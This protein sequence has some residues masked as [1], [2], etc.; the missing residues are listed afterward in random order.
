MLR[1]S[2]VP[3]RRGLQCIPRADSAA[4]PPKACV[5]R[6]S[7]TLR[8]LGLEVDFQDCP[9]VTAAAL[10]L[11]TTIEALGTQH[12]RTVSSMLSLAS[13]LSSVGRVQESHELMNQ[14]AR[15]RE[16]VFAT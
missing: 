1:R 13:T 8:E 10:N 7:S 11:T 14:A 15:L 5:T 3:L 12:P 4:I 16:Q 6:L 9:N 2:M